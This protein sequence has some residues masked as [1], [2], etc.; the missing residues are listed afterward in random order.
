[1]DLWMDENSFA[2]LTR[3]ALGC[4][5]LVSSISLKVFLNFRHRIVV[6]SHRNTPLFR[7]S[8]RLLR[9]SRH[10]PP[11]LIRYRYFFA[12]YLQFDVNWFSRATAVGF[13]P[14]IANSGPELFWKRLTSGT[15]L[16]P[17]ILVYLVKRTLLFFSILKISLCR[18]WLLNVCRAERE[19]DSL[20][21]LDS[22]EMPLS[23]SVV[24][25]KS[26]DSYAL[27]QHVKYFLR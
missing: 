16:V 6:Y 21:F 2:S 27:F 8:S 22:L 18:R 5:C 9:C 12:A 20:L 25:G 26:S 11:L 1:M 4:I 24:C 10:S 13:A 23:R 17:N 15:E 14:R 7:I 3:P 19:N